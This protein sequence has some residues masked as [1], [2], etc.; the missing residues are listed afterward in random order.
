MKCD[1]CGI[2]MVE[3]R[4]QR[5]TVKRVGGYRREETLCAVCFG[6]LSVALA[7]ARVARVRK[8]RARA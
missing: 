8:T 4:G 1:K 6:K 5:V 2:E 7:P 3:G